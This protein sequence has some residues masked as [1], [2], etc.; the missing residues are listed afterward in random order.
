[1]SSSAKCKVGSRLR[2]PGELGAGYRIVDLVARSPGANALQ[3]G[4]RFWSGVGPIRT[5]GLVGFADLKILR[6]QVLASSLVFRCHYNTR[7]S[8]NVFGVANRFTAKRRIA[9]IDASVRRFSYLFNPDE[10]SVH[11]LL[12]PRRFLFVGSHRQLAVPTLRATLLDVDDESAFCKMSADGSHYCSC[13]SL[14]SR[15]NIRQRMRIRAVII[16]HAFPKPRIFH[17]GGSGSS[18]RSQKTRMATTAIA[19]K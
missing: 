9:T 4:R 12:A 13:S 19:I 1:M 10:F 11:I 15:R 8:G 17:L 7:T 16:L 5:H 18:S 14:K 6:Y 2:L 3:N